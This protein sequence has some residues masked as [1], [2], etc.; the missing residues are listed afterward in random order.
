MT[1]AFVSGASVM[2]IEL[3]ANRIL[4][5]MFGNSLYTWTG[6]IGVILISLGVGY[7]LGGWLVDRRPDFGT[8]LA[9]LASAAF[10]VLLIPVL[11]RVLG[12]GF[13][14]SDVVWGPTFASLA[15]FA[16]PGCLLGSISP[17]VARLLSLTRGD[18]SIG[19]SVGS[20]G[21]LSTVGSVVGT[22]M[23]G[24]WLIPNMDLRTLFVSVSAALFAIAGIGYSVLVFPR[25]GSRI[26]PLVVLIG[27]SGAMF[28]SLW[29]SE[30]S[31]RGILF[32]KNSFYH[33]IRVAEWRSPGREVVW[34]LYLDTTIE[35]AQPKSSS[36]VILGY[37]QYWELANVLCSRME[38]AVFLGGGAFAMPEALCRA[39]PDAVVEVVEIDPEVIEV[40]KRFFKLNQHPELRTYT[41]DARRHLADSPGGYD[42]IFGDVYNG[43][44]YVPH[45]LVTR[46]FFEIVRSRLNVDGVYMMNAI[47]ALTGDGSHLFQSICRTLQEV[48]DHVFVF[49]SNQDDLDETQHVILVASQRDLS[50]HISGEQARGD[51]AGP[52]VGRLLSTFVSPGRYHCEDAPVFTD[53]YNPVEYI[54]ARSLD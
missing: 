27:F 32:E 9:I 54:I 12:G 3:A 24:F 2:I 28:G 31:P 46:E 42:L 33:R 17:F 11:Q 10:F 29:V 4:A 13:E 16:I 19:L 38:R 49:A 7:Y 22:F 40:G 35:G 14:T 1:I 26:T 18:K 25:R 48:F 36:R 20:I 8:L 52:V 44:R 53:Y 30:Q 15:F 23:A 51:Q 6:V 5:P 43:L 41:A 45:H 39:Y 37:Q 34:A 50:Q 47:S 21:M